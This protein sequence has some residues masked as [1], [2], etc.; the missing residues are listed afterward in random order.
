M[1]NLW[2]YSFQFKFTKE[3]E[4]KAVVEQEFAVF[5]CETSKANIPVDWFINDK[6]V[7]VGPKYQVLAEDN[8]HKLSINMTRVEDEG[9]IKA[10]FR[11]AVT[12][13]QLTV[14]RK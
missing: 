1:N 2:V 7:E 3:L 4:D 5:E 13:A 14:Q 6:A 12:T 10:V 8:Q 11:K 9:E